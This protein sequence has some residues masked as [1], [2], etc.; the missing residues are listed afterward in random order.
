MYAGMSCE[1]GK[2]KRSSGFLNWS[3]RR[4]FLYSTLTVQFFLLVRDSF[5]VFGWARNQYFYFGCVDFACL[6][7]CSLTHPSFG[8]SLHL[9]ADAAQAVLYL[10]GSFVVVEVAEDG[11]V[12]FVYGLL[13]SAYNCGKDIGGELAH[14]VDES[15]SAKTWLICLPLL[16]QFFTLEMPLLYEPIEY[17]RDTMAAKRRVAGSYA[18]CYLCA[19]CT[20]CFIVFLPDQ[21]VDVRAWKTVWRRSSWYAWGVIGA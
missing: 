3:W 17:K 4:M 1:K 2:L 20:L 8:G 16:P 18:L 7:H 15:A 11:N 10:A 5:T 14:Q 6:L 12:G 21:K 9:V 13:T 19:L